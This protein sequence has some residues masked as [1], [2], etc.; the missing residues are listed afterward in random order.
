ML[1][2]KAPTAQERGAKGGRG[3]KGD[4]APAATAGAFG[5]T[6][7][8]QARAVYRY[9]PTTGQSE[10]SHSAE[11]RYLRARQAA[12]ATPS[13]V[14]ISTPGQCAIML[15]EAWSRSE[16]CIPR[17]PVPAPAPSASSAEVQSWNTM[18]R[19]RFIARRASWLFRIGQRWGHNLPHESIDGRGRDAVGEQCP[20][21]LM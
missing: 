20:G 17:R 13:A 7:L 8:K 6:L 12:G 1:F 10:T 14:G 3:N 11:P 16:G 5:D 21:H 15:A 9:S 18:A 4:K 2:P 19:P